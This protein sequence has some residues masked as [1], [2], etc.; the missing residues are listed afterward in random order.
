MNEAAT[1]RVIEDRDIPDL[2]SKTL[3]G[4]L[5]DAIDEALEGLIG[6]KAKQAVYDHLA[7][8]YSLAREEIPRHLDRFFA[9]TDTTFGEKGTKTIAKSIAKRLWERLGWRFEDIR[10]LEFEEYIELARGRI[11]R[12][13]V[14]N[15]KS[16]ISI[17]T[18][19]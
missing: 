7:R 1:D 4:L 14:Q 10:G 9:L 15:A 19:D 17:R 6:N 13:L 5:V 8:N 18:L 3:D 2:Y 11:A 12:E 16:S